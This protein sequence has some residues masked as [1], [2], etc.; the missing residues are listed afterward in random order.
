MDAVSG[1]GVEFGLLPRGIEEKGYVGH[2]PT[3]KGPTVEYAS[4]ELRL[5]GSD[6]E[7]MGMGGG[8]VQIFLLASLFRLRGVLADFWTFFDPLRS[9]R[10]CLRTLIT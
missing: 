1:E 9:Q 3:N 10:I 8:A 4:K 5:L 7:G 6:G 2:R